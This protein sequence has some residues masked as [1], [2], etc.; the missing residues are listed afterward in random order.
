MSGPRPPTPWATPV[1]W[2]SADN[3]GKTIRVTF[4]FDNTTLVLSSVTA[5]RTPGCAYANIYFGL[6]ADGRPDST[7]QVFANVSAGV[8]VAVPAVTLAAYGFT[9][10]T[11]VFNT[12]QI[13]AGP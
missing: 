6:G 1:T 2:L 7:V 11:D 12:A 10:I 13:T 8:A 4:V 5:T 9:A 3:A